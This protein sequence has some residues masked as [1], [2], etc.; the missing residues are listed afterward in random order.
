MKITTP[1]PLLGVIRKDLSSGI[2]GVL[3]GQARMIPVE[4][5]LASPGRPVQ[6]YRFEVANDR[7]LLPLLLNMTVFSAIGSTERQVGDS[8]LHVDYSIALEGGLP[9]IKAESF[10]SGTANG[11]A[12][13]AR[14]VATPL[15]Y[16]MQSGLGPLDVRSIGIKVVSTNERRTRELEQVWASKREVKRGESVEV[17]ALLRDQDGQEMVQKVAVEIPPS[18]PAGPLWISVADGQSMD[19]LEAGQVGRSALPRN[20]LQLVRAI[21]RSRRN[22]RLYVRLALP[23]IGFQLQGDSFP[24]PPPSVVS[25]LT[26]DGSV[27]TNVSRTVLSTVADYELDPVPGVVAGVKTLTLMIKE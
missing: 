16:L 21:N 15:A 6:S 12:L 20:P 2:F 27:S 4:M 22:N 26:G 23:A 3:G 14:L 18:T 8:T 7:F 13:A 25:T 9:E 5:E 17:T 19:R 10:V 24:S 1:G 11:P